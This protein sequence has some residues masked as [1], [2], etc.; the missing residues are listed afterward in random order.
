MV[1]PLIHDGYVF[2]GTVEP[3]GPFDGFRFRYRPALPEEVMEFLYQRD[4]V[5]GRAQMKPTVEFLA[6]HLVG[7]DIKDKE[8]ITP[9]TPDAL[10]R[11]HFAHQTQLL[12]HIMGYAKSEAAEDAKNSAGASSSS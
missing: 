10:R 8:E 4:Q 11:L 9:V 6:K 3:V 1:A 12:D 5:Q 2:T 7:W